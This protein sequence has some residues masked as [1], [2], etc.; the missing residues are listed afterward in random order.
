MKYNITITMQA[1]NDLVTITEILS[2]YSQNPAEIFDNNFV[3]FMENISTMPY[4][5]P[6]DTQKPKYRRA[7]IAYGYIAFY[8]VIK[9]K[10]SILIYRVLNSKQNI[11]NLL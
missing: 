7:A 5:Y 6:Q 11:N 10:H 8:K 2:E 9:S 4:I 3:S 1:N